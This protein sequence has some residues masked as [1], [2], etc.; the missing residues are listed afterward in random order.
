MDI[1][2]TSRSV[3]CEKVGMNCSC[4]CVDEHQFST[5]T[6]SERKLWLRAI[7]NVKVKLQNEAPAPTIEEIEHYRFAIKE[8]IDQIKSTLVS[9][10]PMDALL[11]LL[12]QNSQVFLDEGIVVDEN[13]DEYALQ[14]KGQGMGR[15]GASCCKD[16]GLNGEVSALGASN[17][18]IATEQSIPIQT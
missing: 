6:L 2:I 5:R 16:V 7:S 14:N 18:A 4:F 17:R 8:H 15:E 11:Q 10:A 3:C 13:V 1:Y 12:P 9:K